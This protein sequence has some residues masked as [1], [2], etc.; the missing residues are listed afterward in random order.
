MD[1]EEYFWDYEIILYLTVAVYVTIHRNIY[2]QKV[3]IIIFN[4]K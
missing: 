1:K 4:E 3:F 2:P